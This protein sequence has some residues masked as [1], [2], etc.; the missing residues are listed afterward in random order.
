[1]I[2][3]VPNRDS[4]PLD[5]DPLTRT[6]HLSLKVRRD[7][8]VSVHQIP[9]GAPVPPQPHLSYL[10]GAIVLCV[11]AALLT[12]HLLKNAVPRSGIYLLLTFTRGLVLTA[13]F[14]CGFELTLSVLQRLGVPIVTL[15]QVRK[16]LISSQNGDGKG[17]GRGG[18]LRAAIRSMVVQPQFLLTVMIGTSAGVATVL[19]QAP[20]VEGTD[21][22]KQLEALQTRLDTAS[23]DIK[24]M[25]GPVLS[26]AG[27]QGVIR[28]QL[29]DIK[30]HLPADGLEIRTM[31]RFDS[32]DRSFV[33]LQGRLTHVSGENL[34]LSRRLDAVTE[35]LSQTQVSLA[36]I[37][38]ATQ[39]NAEKLRDIQSSLTDI[40]V[41]AKSASAGLQVKRHPWDSSGPQPTL[42]TEIY[43]L[44]QHEDTL[45]KRISRLIAHNEL[46]KVMEGPLV[47]QTQVTAPIQAARSQEAG[48]ESR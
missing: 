19:V 3:D 13:F 16:T 25:K 43:R 11:I 41:W 8:I 24:Q 34:A 47:A 46:R 38:A 30:A 26:L 35:G 48:V 7:E 29:A 15:N 44:V 40:G 23:D 18:A 31:G 6:L 39:M 5:L 32:L 22:T 14:I 21:Y 10:A 28:G 33:T 4:Q 37:K 17:G 1:M 36:D 42:A 9:E 27:G 2:D 20:P 12:D 45:D